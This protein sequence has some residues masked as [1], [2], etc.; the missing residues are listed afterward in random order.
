MKEREI[1]SPQNTMERRPELP[2][3]TIPREVLGLLEQFRGQGK[4]AYVVGG[5]LRDAMLGRTPKDWDITTDA[6]PDEM[7]QM[8]GDKAFYENAF[9]TVGIKTGSENTALALVEAT[10]FRVE[11]KYS[12]MRHPDEVQFAKTVE[13]DLARRDFTINAMAYDGR[14]L[15]DPYG[16]REDLDAKK[17]R[18]VGDPKERFNEDA[19]RLMRA[20]RFAAS[21]D[22]TIEPETLEAVRK[23]AGLL[24][25]VAKERVGEEFK[26]LVMT[27]RADYG[28]EL[29]RETG[30]LRSVLP[31][32]EEGWGIGQNKHH[33]YTVWEHNVLALRYAADNNL[34]VDVR[35]ASLL[36]DVGKPRVK[37]GDGLD[38]TFYGH[39]VV[40]ARMAIQMLE[41]L[42]F[43]KAEIE[44]IALLVRWHMFQS[45]ME[46]LSDAG[47]RRFIANVRPEN[48]PDILAV[49]R[50][51]R[52][53]SGVKKERPYRLRDF[54]ARV[55]FLATKFISRG[56]MAADGH[57][58]MQGLKLEPGKRLGAILDAL[59]EEVLDDPTFNT[60]EYLIE[61][62]T[63]LNVHSDEEL[64]EMRR[65]AKAKYQEALQGEEEAIKARYYVR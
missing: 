35:I 13:E 36:H 1:A 62:A 11:G 28:I 7:L 45:D 20:V 50:A 57:A 26:K 21:L 9:G 43:S 38:S 32:L 2:I 63:A 49:R 55:E 44:K 16:G 53:G 48:I 65:T 54:E 37:Q 33:V 52:I 30:L 3:M 15:V 46:K 29:L 17:I 18:A 39:E 24:E 27:D 14:H 25:R 19:L 64:E 47:I 31:E 4:Q 12:D 51:D 41:R 40:G 60:R 61:R 6:T 42:K 34:S 8:F 23:N 5:C 59:F 58:L 56:D 10:T 22:F